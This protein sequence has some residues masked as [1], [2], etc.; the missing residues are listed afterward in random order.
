M[1]NSFCHETMQDLVIEE[2]KLREVKGRECIKEEWKRGRDEK[3]VIPVVLLCDVA[4]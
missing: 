4:T 2:G 3:W 1:M